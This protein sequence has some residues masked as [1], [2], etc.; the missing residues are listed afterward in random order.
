MPGAV[1]RLGAC[2]LHSTGE[3]AITATIARAFH[4][5]GLKLDAE[6]L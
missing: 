5:A 1:V 2:G 4:V 6:A 3:P